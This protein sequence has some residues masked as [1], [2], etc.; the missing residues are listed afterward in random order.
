MYT[1]HI[2]FEN[3]EKRRQTTTIYADSYQDARNEFMRRNPY[4][5]IIGCHQVTDEY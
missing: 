5:A 4:C 1:F 2:T 3:G